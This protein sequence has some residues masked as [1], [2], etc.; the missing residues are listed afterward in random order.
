MRIKHIIVITDNPVRKQ[1]HIQ[2]KFKRAYL[3]LSCILLYDFSGKACFM[4][5]QIINRCI[6]P[7][8]MSFCIGT[9]IRIAFRFFLKA[10]FFFGGQYDTL[11]CQ[12]PVPQKTVGI[13][14]HGPG[15]GLCR[16]IKNFVPHSLSH[17]L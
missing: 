13:F 1:A 3:M 16:Q 10:Y 2:T 4:C 11:K 9:G 8:I 15:N 14:C 6:Y 12:T 5:Q 7:V 17:S